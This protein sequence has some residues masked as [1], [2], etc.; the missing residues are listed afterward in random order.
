MSSSYLGP[1]FGSRGQVRKER[2]QQEATLIAEVASSGISTERRDRIRSQ[3][4][5]EI[6]SWY[7]PWAHLMATTGIGVL[8]LLLGT[9]QLGKLGPVKAS[10]LLIIPITFLL[11]NLFEWRV[12]KHVLHR[13][14][15]PMEILYDKH[16]PMHHMIY[17]EED[18]TLRSQREFR[19]VL[20]PAAGVLGVVLVTTP[21]AVLI[22]ALWSTAAGWMFLVSASLY[23]VTYE[24]LH[25]AYH[26]P[27]DSFIGRLR[28][29]S[30]MRRHHARH[31]NP[32]LMQRYNFN[33]IIP[34]SDYLLGTMAPDGVEP[35]ASTQEESS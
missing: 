33:V 29:I 1:S 10:D 25:L 23:M 6:P 2:Q 16:T 12:H 31:H 30:A 20:I 18:M 7:N 8:A 15:W 11:A 14:R 24:L 3:A 34:L 13:R 17:I 28:F 32:R 35:R 26:A 19:L 22:S 27:K 5:S 4:V 9:W 21:F